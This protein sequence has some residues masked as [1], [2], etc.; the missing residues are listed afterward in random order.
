MTSATAS[1][2]AATGKQVELASAG[3]RAVITEVG[4]HLRMLTAGGRPLIREFDA[5]QIP[6]LYSGAVLAPWPNRIADGRYRFAGNGFQLPVN[7]VDRGNALHGLVHDRPWTIGGQSP[8]SVLLQHRIWPTAGYPFRLDLSLR[9]TLDPDGL[10]FE[11]SARNSGAG[12]APYGC[13]IHP[14]LVAGEGTVDDWTLTMP[15]ERYLT[16]DAQR[17]LPQELRPVEGDRS[18]EFD[19]RTAR[20]LEGLAIDHAFTGL[21]TDPAGA[22]SL[23]LT[24]ADGGGVRMS[25]GA[26]TPWVQL[27]TADRPEPDLDRT[28]LA[29]EPMTCPPDAFNSGTDLVTL[30]PDDEHTTMIRIAALSTDRTRSAR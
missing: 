28:A 27:C 29:A 22:S 11:L 10:T 26:A 18:G 2:S 5:A 7:E 30:R 12:D 13:S 23:E 14:Y 25:W 1:T 16:V 8:D 4:G 9:Y 3:Y 21:A 20:S 24:A 15:A 19:F 6:P 17:L